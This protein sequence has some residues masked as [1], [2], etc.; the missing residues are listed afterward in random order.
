MLFAR[1]VA[2]PQLCFNPSYI[3]LLVCFTSSACSLLIMFVSDSIF[4]FIVCS[5][6]VRAFS[7]STAFWYSGD[8]VEVICMIAFCL[9]I[10]FWIYLS[11]PFTASGFTS[12]SPSAIFASYCYSVSSLICSYNLDTV[13]VSYGFTKLSCS[14]ALDNWL[15]I[16]FSEPTTTSSSVVDL[17]TVKPSSIFCASAT[18]CKSAICF[19]NDSIV[20][21]SLV[22]VFRNW[23]DNVVICASVSLRLPLVGALVVLP[24]ATTLPVSP[25]IVGNTVSSVSVVTLTSYFTVT[26]ALLSNPSH[27][28]KSFHHFAIWL[29]TL[30]TASSK[31]FHSLVAALKMALSVMALAILSQTGLIYVFHI[32]VTKAPITVTTSFHTS[33]TLVSIYTILDIP[34]IVILILASVICM[35]LLSPSVI[36]KA[37]QDALS[38]LNVSDKLPLF[39]SIYS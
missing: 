24:V 3:S 6:R 8:S 2:A 26:V 1:P 5:Y 16:S 17:S 23:V 25:V 30:Y 15:S 19:F 31:P 4:T 7:V 37:F 27:F 29:N 22:S 34:S 28:L 12:T 9:A 35:P 11:E 39:V 38:M 32:L 18:F 33:C 21:L 20:S 13:S 14:F 10:S 36:I